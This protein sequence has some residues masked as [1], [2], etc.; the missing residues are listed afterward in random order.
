M[1]NLPSMIRQGVFRAIRT[2]RTLWTL[3]RFHFRIGLAVLG[4]CLDD[5]CSALC[6]VS[7]VR[8]AAIGL[9]RQTWR[10]GA[11]VGTTPGP[12]S[13]PHLELDFEKIRQKKSLKREFSSHVIQN[14]RWSTKKWKFWKISKT[15]PRTQDSTLMKQQS[16]F[17]KKCF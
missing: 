6:G 5:F 7:D 17:G 14:F 13:H 2:I 10:R 16:K 12:P 4:E 11:A 1:R 3:E 8:S 9:S 15:F